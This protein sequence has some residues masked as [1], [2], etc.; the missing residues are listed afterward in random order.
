MLVDNII[1]TC[2]A[3]TV[4]ENRVDHGGLGETVRHY[5]GVFYAND[6]MVS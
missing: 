4:E 1:I 6:G 3:M 2:L 5:L